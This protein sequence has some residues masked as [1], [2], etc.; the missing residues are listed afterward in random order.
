L[1]TDHFRRTRMA[2]GQTLPGA[3]PG[4]PYAAVCYEQRQE[5]AKEHSGEEGL[6][7]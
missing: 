4:P 1:A 2:S 3:G 5:P 7:R 6:R